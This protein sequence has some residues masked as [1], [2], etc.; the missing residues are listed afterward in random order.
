MP[1][2]TTPTRSWSRSRN[3]RLRRSRAAPWTEAPSRAARRACGS[4]PQ[5]MPELR[6]SG[7]WLCPSCARGTHRLAGSGPRRPCT[8][9]PRRIRDRLSERAQASLPRGWA[10]LPTPAHLRQPSTWKM[11]GMTCYIHRRRGITTAGRAR[12]VT[13][14]RAPEARQVAGC[15]Q[16]E[17][18]D[19]SRNHDHKSNQ[20][21]DERWALQR[22]VALQGP[23]PGREQQQPLTAFHAAW[24]PRPSHDAGNIAE[25]ER[26]A[27]AERTMRPE[28]LRR[29]SAAQFPSSRAARSRRATV[30]GMQ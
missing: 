28:N 15:Q 21:F 13:S 4:S 1:P 11:I 9:C 14:P 2:P 12:A 26:V 18:N 16:S 25:W 10:P 30:S 5:P 29:G 19:D 3:A 17:G 8:P 20:V 23:R 7:I 24:Q 27:A 6:R 22:V